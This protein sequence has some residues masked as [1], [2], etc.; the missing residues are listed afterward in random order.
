LTGLF[1]FHEGGSKKRVWGKDFPHVS[2]ELTRG[3]A[4]S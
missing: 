3:V 4:L 2:G 1:Y